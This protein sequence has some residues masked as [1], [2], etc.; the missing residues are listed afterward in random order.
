MINFILGK[1][2][3]GKTTH[4]YN[5]IEQDI[6]NNLNVILFVPSQC[7]AKAENEYMKILNKNGVIGVNITTISE[8]VKEQLKIQNLHIDEKYMSKL[9]RKI[10]LTQV[11]KENPELFNIFKRVKNYPGFLDVLDIYMDLLRKSEIEVKDYINVEV[12]DKR[13]DEKF[14]EILSVYDKY[15]EKIKAN[16]IDSVDEMEIFLSNIAK[17]EYFLDNKNIN[18]Y[19]DGYN[20]FTNSE[21]K[22]LDTLIKKR[23]NM[24]IT[25]NTD[26]T[27]IEEIYNSASIFE[28]SNKTYKRI[29]AMASKNDSEVENIVKYEN[30]FDTK[31]DIKYV[32][33]N[34]FGSDNKGKEKIELQNVEVTMHTNVLKEIEAVAKNISSKIKEGCRFSDFAIYTTNVEE[35]DKVISRIFYENNLEIYVSK[36]KSISDSILTK[37]IQGLLNLASK[38]LNLEL[39]F[40]ILKL[41][42]TDIDLKEIYLLE[43]YM[44]EFNV[45]KYLVNNKF[46]LNNSSNG[47]DL[48]KLN[49]IKNRIVDMY[50]FTMAIKE[51]TCKD[52]IATIYEHLESQNIFDNFLNITSPL[53]QDVINLD[54]NNFEKQVWQHLTSI[55]DSIVKVY[56]DEILTIEEFSNVF[57]LVVKDLKIKTLPPTKD[58]IELVDINV[59]KIEAKKYIFFIGVVERKFPK[60]VDED[61]FFTDNELE[62]LKDKDIDVRETT[63]SKLNMGF[64]N[65]Y[66]ALNNVSKKLYIHIPS[67]TLD[68]KAT[69][70]SSF[71]TLLEQISKVKIK[72]EVT[73]DSKSNDIYDISSKDELFMWLIRS[74]RDL[75]E[76]QE[77]SEK[78]KIL[79]VY[80]YFKKDEKYSKI[81]EFKKDDSKLSKEITDIIY[82][83]EF[84]TSVS[85]LELYK[86]CPF[87]YF[88]Q[89]ILKV[90]PNKEAKVNVLELGSFMHNV[91][92]QFSKILLIKDIKWQAILTEDLEDIT[93]EYENIL[94]QV[95]EESIEANLSKQKQSVK[96]MVLKRKLVNTMKKV[97][98]TVALSYNQ[99]EFEPYGYEIEFKDNS[100]FLP[101]QIKLDENRIMKIIGKIDRV[102]ML[103]HK[104]NM[105]IRVVD[106]K[107]SSKELKVDKI[108]EGISLQLISYLIAFMENKNTQKI[109]PAGILYFNLSDKLVALSQYEQDNENIKKALM[110]KLKMNGIFIKDIEILNKMDRNFECNQA[111]SLIDITTRSLNSSSKKALEEKE[112]EDLCQKTKQLLKE[113]GKDISSGIVKIAPNKKEDYCKFCNYSTTCRK[114]LEV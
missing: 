34:L 19:F 5:M 53:K 64:F 54:M 69:R 89:Y 84:K 105:Y 45:N 101:M 21:Y 16:Y 109:K 6:A 11:I 104:D 74:I 110:K 90:C 63:I 23:I 97:I 55:F 66:E 37:Y 77:L 3:T 20:N 52:I 96:Y 7:R 18:V 48:D 35:Y 103:E 46:T 106:Y 13:V 108:K 56:K 10:V 79:S 92:E 26:I 114:N 75:K 111:N 86:K 83:N 17:C 76:E 73:Q 112:F 42:L 60:K 87:S 2:K 9:D 38:G 99:S 43:N 82:S 58:Q 88:M 32:A 113:I 33:N 12:G 67:A 47:Y 57:N 28:V 70:K 80:E 41:G 4:I 1:S 98:R 62:K 71:I 59:S 102:D 85:R 100:V 91:L 72:G 24:T 39:I 30:V 68:G 51:G 27:R 29:C 8:F 25:L 95:I 81:L 31:E 50:S 22:F 36:S 78:E 107:S 61:I 14:K 40:N 93:P 49:E 15:L 94:N 65:I 44:R